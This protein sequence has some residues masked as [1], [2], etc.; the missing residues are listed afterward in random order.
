MPGFN[1]SAD[2]WNSR[3]EVDVTGDP[4]SPERTRLA[5]AVVAGLTALFNHEAASLPPVE[6]RI[7]PKLGNTG[8]LRIVPETHK[9]YVDD[10][11]VVL[12]ALEFRLLHVLQQRAPRVQSRRALLS[13]AWPNNG[14][15]TGEGA[16]TTVVRRLRQKLGP[17]QHCIENVRGVGYVFAAP[18][19]K[20]DAGRPSI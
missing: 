15:D 18:A 11:P 6:L 10:R 8:Q 7:A 14:E 2:D 5:R 1:S 9:A 4:V 12:S 17:A 13:A 20:G 16:V 3:T 19:S